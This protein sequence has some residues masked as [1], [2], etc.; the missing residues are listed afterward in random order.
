MAVKPCRGT[1]QPVFWLSPSIKPFLV[2]PQPE[3]R[4]V[5]GNIGRRSGG[6]KSWKLQQPSFCLQLTSL[7]FQVTKRRQCLQIVYFK[8]L[9]QTV[10]HGSIRGPLEKC[11]FMVIFHEA[12]QIDFA[13]V[14]YRLEGF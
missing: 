3:H 4:P 11:C 9:N 10:S 7:F 5:P 6:Q 1:W 14:G 12:I 8:F 13:G 2:S